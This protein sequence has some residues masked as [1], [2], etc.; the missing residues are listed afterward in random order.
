MNKTTLASIRKLAGGTNDLYYFIPDMSKGP[1]S[2]ILGYPVVEFDD[3]DAAGSGNLCI[4]FGNFGVGYQIVDRIGI[5]VLRDPYT[6]KPYIRYYTTKRVGG[7]VT[8]F[9]AIKFIKCT[10]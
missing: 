8:N 5:R 3:M 1:N 2:Q 10:T 6:N 9:D 4:A 7:D